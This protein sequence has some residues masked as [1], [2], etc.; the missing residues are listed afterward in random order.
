[1]RILYLLTSLGIGGAERQTLALAR[2]MAGRGHQIRFMV[3]R[4]LAQEC[5]LPF[6]ADRLGLRKSPLS[7]ARGLLQARACVRAFQP[8]VLHSHGFHAN[9]FARALRCVAPMPVLISTVHNVY[10]GGRA[11]MLAYRLSDR[12]STRTTTVSQAA[13][14]RFIQLKAISPERCLVLLNAIELAEFPPDPQRRE[15]TRAAM[16]AP[17]NFIWLAAGRISP[18]KDYPN[19]LRAFARLRPQSHPT[20]LWIAGEDR[21][22]IQPALQSLAHD[23]GIHGAVHWLGLRRDL[24]A[25]LDAAD[26]FVLSSAW[27]GMPLAVAEAMAMAKPVIATN[28]GGVS[29]LLAD[30]GALV[31]PKD[32]EAL[33]TAMLELMR[34]PAS[35][36][37]TIARAAR[38]R[39]EAHFNMHSRAAEWEQLYQSLGAQ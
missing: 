15:S 30:T 5:L 19:L 10:E 24:P 32:P 21:R 3:L 12:L 38:A 37:E 4:S 26:A 22:G 29:E 16:N 17:G 25:L 6:P 31:P 20:Q 11:R 14:R 35:A 34:Q 9:I 28:A 23:L 33:A 2:Q 8:D 7:A 1:M 13:A 39:I 18:A 36:R 27:E